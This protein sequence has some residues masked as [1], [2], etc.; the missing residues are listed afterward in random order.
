MQSIT[1]MWNGK[2]K[3]SSQKQGVEKLLPDDRK[4]GESGGN[5]ERLENSTDF[6]L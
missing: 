5:N 2:Y 3:P 1:Y 4:V 6:E